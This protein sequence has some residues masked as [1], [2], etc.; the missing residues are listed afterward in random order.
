MATN[1]KTAPKKKGKRGA[2]GAA[3]AAPVRLV[4]LDSHAILHRA[5]HALPDFSTARGEPT[6]AL[7]GLCLMILAAAKDLKPDFVAAAFDLAKPTYRHEAYKDYKAGRSKTDDALSKQINR[8]R[9]IFKAL[10]I[11]I[12]EAEGFEADDVLGTIAEQLRDRPNVKVIIASGDMDTLQLVEDGRVTVYTLRKGLKDTVTYDEA[13]VVARYSFGPGHVPDYKGLAGDPSD[14]IVGVPGVGEKTAKQLIAT[15]DS[16]EKMYVALKKDPKTFREKA[17]V[18]ERVANLLTEHEEEAT[19]SKMLATIRR[20]APVKVDL[21]AARRWGQIDLSAARTLFNELEFRSLVPKLVD[22]AGGTPE[23]IAEAE[24]EEEAAPEVSGDP[25]ALA[26]ASVALW[27]LDSTMANPSASD[28]AHFAGTS[29]LEAARK[30]I[31]AELK[32]RGVWNVFE[33]I[34][35]PIVPVIARMNQTGVGLDA[36]YLRELAA[37][38]KVK[39]AKLEKDI[40][41]LAGSDFNLNSPRQ[42]GEVLFVKLGIG[43]DKLKKTPGGVPSTREEVLEGLFD[44]HP[45][46]P[47]ILE[48][49]E[50]EKLRSTYLEKLPQLV[51]PDGR[52]HATFLQAGAATGRMASQNPGLQNIPIKGE[53]GPRIRRGF[54]APR[55]KRLLALDY[56]QIELR[57][58]AI[59]AEDPKLAAAFREGRDIH[60]EVASEVFGVSAEKVTKEMRRQAKVINF[61]VL[62]GMGVNALQKNLG[63]PR[64]EAQA[65]YGRY[66]E[67]FP[68][69]AGYIR[70]TKAEAAKKGFTETLFGRR[71]HLDGF[72]SPLPFVRASAERMAVNAPMQGTA[73]DMIKLAMGR[74]DALIEE[75]GWRGKVELVLQVH[76]ELVDEVDEALVTDASVAI[77]EAMSGVLTPESLRECGVSSVNQAMVAKMGVPVTVEAAAGKNWAEM[78]PVKVTSNN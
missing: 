71:R 49:R 8:A 58:A 25:I 16:I 30:K 63:V 27:L 67:A 41:K 55:G 47:K 33:K 17:K 6:G 5:Y 23:A 74:A 69:L 50:L 76:D 1:K 72:S 34:E 12:L 3:P 43:G 40:H 19:F 39:L 61:G 75:R 56:S 15:F 54:V 70:K 77:G 2:A 10:N 66:F 38:Y 4:L 13:A 35:Q 48:Y 37:E 22:L 9:D 31:F 32:S 20:D 42:L 24:P 46:V 26:E 14:N 78:S 44:A 45:I 51:Q 29:D 64:A 59:L 7:Y 53:H 11:P 60:A 73:A 65:F 36:P 21:S 62:Y 52:L 18:T 57:V 28:I 68:S